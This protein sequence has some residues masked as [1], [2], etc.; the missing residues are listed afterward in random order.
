MR[1]NILNIQEMLSNKIGWSYQGELAV[2]LS[3]KGRDFVIYDGKPVRVNAFSYMLVLSGKARLWIDA[4]EYDVFRNVLCMMSPLHQTCFSQVSED[5]QC[6]FLCVNKRFVDRM[7]SPDIQ[8]HIARGMTRY[9]CPLIVVSEEERQLLEA[10]IFDIR[11][12]L[13][14]REHLYYL[15]MIQNALSRFYLETDHIWDRKVSDF[16]EMK[17]GNSRYNEILR[18]FISLLMMYFK[19]EHL[20]PFYADALHMTPQYLTLIVKKQTGKTVN[21][22]IGEMLYSESRNLLAISGLSIQQIAAELNFADQS[23]F[24]KFFK[25]QAGVSPLEYRKTVNSSLIS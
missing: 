13:L 25:K 7:A 11:N 10:G 6:L 21:D 5:Y 24:C 2:F 8:H 22:F 12:Q 4:E 16:P 23:S 17:G 20:V 15:E 14:R 3:E 18:K 1:Y 19:T 9:R